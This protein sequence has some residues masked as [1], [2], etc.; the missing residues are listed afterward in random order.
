MSKK[1]QKKKYAT[2]EAFES[3]EQ[4]VQKSE[5]FLEKNA[6]T[7][8]IVFGALILVAVL[9]FAYLKFYQEPQNQNAQQ[10]IVTADQM[11]EQDSMQAALNGSPGAYLGYNQI[12]DEYGGTD[13]GNLAKYKA[14]IALYQT[15]DYKGALEKFKSFSAKEKAMKAMKQGVMGDALV[16]MGE[17]EKGLDAYEK[18]V[19]ASDLQ[20]IQEIYTKKSAILA[21]DLG[22]FERGYKT[23]KSF[24][25]KNSNADFNKDLSKLAEML[26]NAK[27]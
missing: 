10:E 27:K 12:I 26:K 24:L 14:G 3:L 19:N 1:K 6:K 21:Y 25:D 8:G 18:A 13:I 11:F 2:E 4:T 9:Y 16:Q 23:V 22:E 15:G 20:V 17:K 5:H 7:L